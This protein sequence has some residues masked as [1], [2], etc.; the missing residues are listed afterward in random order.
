MNAWEIEPVPLRFE[1]CGYLCEVKRNDH[2]MHLCGYVTVPFGH[3]AHGKGYD[4]VDLDV[5]GGLTFSD[6]G[7]FGFDCAHAGDY[8]PRVAISLGEVGI[9]RDPIFDT[10][11]TYKTVGFVVDQLVS[12]ARQFKQLEIDYVPNT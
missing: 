2:L 8:V 11:E 1:V 7:K 3:P 4:E 6:S 12:L 10:Y 9:T 5:H